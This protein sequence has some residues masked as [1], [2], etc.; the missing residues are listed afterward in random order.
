MNTVLVKRIFRKS[1]YRL[2]DIERELKLSMRLA[3]PGDEVLQVAGR[4]KENRA[5]AVILADAGS[6]S[7]K[8]LKYRDIDRILPH[9]C[10]DPN[11]SLRLAVTV[12]SSAPLL[13]TV[14]IPRGLVMDEF[15][16]PALEVET[17]GD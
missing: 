7:D 9:E 8:C 14:R 1:R 10:R 6:T 13:E 15:R 3:V 4:G 17:L 11:G 16:A 5:K 12:D 2:S